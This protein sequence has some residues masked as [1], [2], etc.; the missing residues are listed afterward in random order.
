MAGSQPWFS[1]NFSCPSAAWVRLISAA[2]RARR[3]RRG[4]VRKRSLARSG[5]ARS[6]RNLATQ[7]PAPSS[8]ANARSLAM[9]LLARVGLGRGHS[10]GDRLP[11]CRQLEGMTLTPLTAWLRLLCSGGRSAGKGISVPR[12]DHV[13]V[14]RNQ[15]SRR[16]RT[17]ARVKGAIRKKIIHSCSNVDRLRQAN[18][19]RGSRADSRGSSVQTDKQRT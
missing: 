18:K 2:G 9:Q 15:T 4:R 11:S 10:G 14:T 8:S 12:R 5:I 7:S 19:E 13:V 16:K 1:L 6:K 3:A 17:S